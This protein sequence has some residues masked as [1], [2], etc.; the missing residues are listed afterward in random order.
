MQL[1]V[2]RFVSLRACGFA[3]AI[4][5]LLG[6]ASAQAQSV[7]NNSGPDWNT[8]ANWSGG[9]PGNSA[10]AEFNSASYAGTQP[11]VGSAIQVGEIWDHGS[12]SLT[13]GGAGPLTINGATATSDGT[14]GLLMDSAGTLT[15][16][17]SM[18]FGGVDGSS[19]AVGYVNVHQGTIQINSTGSWTNLGELN[20]GNVSG[21][22]GTLALS[23]GTVVLPAVQNNALWSGVSVGANGGTGV[24]TL[25]GNSL[26]N[27]TG[28][29]G[30]QDIT[31][32]GVN[33]GSG[34]S[35]G[36]VTVGGN[37]ILRSGAGNYNYNGGYSN[38]SWLT[39]GEGGNGTL[40]IKDNGL[41]TADYFDLG[42]SAN[43]GNAG[44]VGV[45]HL[46]GGTLG[47]PT[48][49]HDSNATGTIYFNGG[50]LLNTYASNQGFVNGSRAT[51]FYAYVQAG[52]AVINT[53]G[54]TWYFETPLLHDPVLLSTD[55][56]LTKLGGGL[57]WMSN[58]SNTYN[59]PTNVSGGTLRLDSPP[60]AIS[61]SAA[62]GTSLIVPSSSGGGGWNSTQ[63]GALLN[64]SN[65]T[66]TA[67]ATLGID[68]SNGDFTYGNNI[69]SQPVGLAK[70]GNNVLTLTG[71]NAYTGGTTVTAGALSAATTGSLPG[72]NT[73]AVS[74]ASGAGLTVQPSNGSV[75]WTSAQISNAL[76]H[77]AFT[78]SAA[79][80]ID[81]SN[82]NSTY[83]GSVVTT[84]GNSV[85]LSMPSGVPLAKVG[86]NALTVVG[87]NTYNG[88][89]TLFSGQLN[90]GDSSALGTGPL[91]ING[92]TIDN[93]SGSDMTLSA[94]NA[95]NWYNG[96]TYAG[97][98]NSLNLGTGTVYFTSPNEQAKVITVSA[99]TLTVGG[100]IMAYNGGY[101]GL[102]K[103]GN[104]TL[105]LNGNNNMLYAWLTVNGGVLTLG[106]TNGM[107]GNYGYGTTLN[108]GQL[109][110][111]NASALGTGDLTING[112][113]IDNTSGGDV[114][115]ST[116]WSEHWNASFTYA[117]AT[118]NLSLTSTRAVTLGADCS[119]TVAAHTLTVGSPITGSHS[120]TKL[121][122]GTLV[123]GGSDTYTGATT[124]S[125]GILQFATP[126]SLYNGATGSW[127]AANIPVGNGATL[128]VSV[129]GTSDFTIGN[130]STL[131]TNL[132]GV[133]SNNGL[134]AGSSIGF[135]TTN[136]TSA[137]TLSSNI[138]DT[139]GPGGGSVGV[140]KLGAG[141]LILTGVNSYTGPTA[142]GAGGTLEFSNAANQILSGSI[143]G[144]GA[145]AT[146]GPG[147]L[148]LN[149]S[150][151][152]S[153][154]TTIGGGTLQMGSALALGSTNG[155]LVV[156][157][158]GALNLNGNS[159]TVGA[160][161]GGGTIDNTTGGGFCTLSVG[162]GDANGD[163]S[164]V[165]QNSS[166]TVALTKIGA[167]N[168]DL[169]GAS[170]YRGPTT[171]SAGTVEI[172]SGND[173]PVATALTIAS[174]GALNLGGN[175]Q[176]VGSLSGAAG[177]IIANN[178]VHPS[179]TYTSSLTVNP[180][181][182]VTTFAG[183]IVDSTLSSSHGNVALT[184]SG[185]GEL[186][187]AGANTYSGGTSVSGGVLEI[188][189][190]SALPGSGLVSISGG[191]RLVLGSGS[192]IGALLSASSP[193]GSREVALSAAAASAPATIGGYEN[194]SGS[195]A[196]LG[197]APP[198]SLGG[199]GGAVGGTAAA[200]PEPGTIALLAAG[201]L[202][203]AVASWR[204]RGG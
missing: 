147:V 199:G 150:N 37:S 28:T 137:V 112:G 183:N 29:G 140:A 139:T 21:Q 181:S 201:I 32:I 186:V 6:G 22:T 187:L 115:V 84:N 178:L 15:V 46:N 12:G 8:T 149:A 188:A 56:G 62:A 194:T 14:I 90:I 5:I 10:I 1:K 190:A 144:P 50:L 203:L 61:G 126:A 159:V 80:G 101:G 36:T 156:N 200:V 124:I 108:A 54:G 195:M 193:A 145:L 52:G 17:T 60:A 107:V 180:A 197:G 165:I 164:G 35:S 151:T 76:S 43:M 9:V 58:S 106:G 45:V 27:A 94:N 143:S 196:T 191:G 162:A 131:L 75:G 65:F 161:T 100:P 48:I 71:T 184:M 73:G 30:N 55:G 132:D 109:N 198:L 153:G 39:V 44:G 177:A 185:N 23:S 189:A 134:Q 7:W 85:N 172:D 171:I 20:L 176:M 86:P 57:L 3:A 38:G 142:I 166:G 119:V 128:A 88:G 102:T 70:F 158:P 146:M 192:G 170:T 34:V 99:N 110:I 87:A 16:A 74:V 53:G 141:T 31:E 204:R 95:Q 13:I 49:T 72:Y 93:T 116:L 111:N 138:A 127:T 129:G 4:G 136:A 125:G 168:L 66:W 122:N 82:G 163:F 47:V 155:S 118:N 81:T 157:S 179:H 117:G 79:F 105:V 89:T 69:A 92:G 148:A 154:G 18:V 11:N 19:N 2:V 103:E 98:T 202:M 63:I 173:L 24:L 96:F 40:T 97:A 104:G 182:G 64:P 160:L 175:S 41:V 167:G 77:V 67:G 26:F 78:G 123:L 133:V 25:T 120:L 51:N 59:G 152:Y 114:T 33:N 113:T 91:T 83:N 169:V 130:V 174:A 121:G 135:D 68:T 42:S